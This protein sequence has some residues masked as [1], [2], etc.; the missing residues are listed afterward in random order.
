MAKCRNQ[1]ANC[2]T[3]AIEAFNQAIEASRIEL[4]PLWRNV[5]GDAPNLIDIHFFRA[6]EGRLERIPACH[7]LVD[8]VAGVHAAQ[9]RI[10]KIPLAGIEAIPLVDE[11]RFVSRS[12]FR[13]A[14]EY[15]LTPICIARPF[16]EHDHSRWEGWR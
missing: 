7:M 2:G 10:R 4:V 3:A 11:R 13:L 12:T 1:R 9:R 15:C 16:I 14:A 6:C 5:R 8:T